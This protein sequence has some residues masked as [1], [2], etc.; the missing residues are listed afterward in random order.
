[1]SE[2][3]EM[4]YAT[5]LREGRLAVSAEAG[6]ADIE[7][8][9]MRP[10]D[11][12]MPV[13]APGCRESALGVRGICSRVGTLWATGLKRGFPKVDGPDAYL[14]VVADTVQYAHIGMHALLALGAKLVLSSPCL[15]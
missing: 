3:F 9:D 13:S 10:N 5:M 15:A 4:T 8:R 6:P 12:L 14:S 7:L 2:L 1:M 11:D